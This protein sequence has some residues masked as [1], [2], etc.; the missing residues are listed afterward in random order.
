MVQKTIDRDLAQPR[1]K[2][3]LKPEIRDRR[4][5]FQPNFLTEI[6]RILTVTAE[7]EGQRVNTP[8]VGLSQHTK[9]VAVTDLREPY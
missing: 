9:S 2:V 5:S 6:F 4:V 3:R 7:M 1:I 8:L